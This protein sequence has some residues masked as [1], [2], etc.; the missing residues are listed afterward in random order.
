MH[1]GVAGQLTPYKISLSSWRPAPYRLRNPIA[2]KEN[3]TLLE[4]GEK[5]LGRLSAARLSKKL[6]MLT[7]SATEPA[8]FVSAEWS[9]LSAEET[10][11]NC[12]ATCERFDGELPFKG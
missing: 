2:A 9:N 11:D 10:L 3:K 4:S 6:E 7:K 5:G 1:G 8:W 12:F